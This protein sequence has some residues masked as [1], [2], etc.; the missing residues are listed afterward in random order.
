MKITSYSAP[1]KRGAL[2]ACMVVLLA[3]PFVSASEESQRTLDDMVITASKRESSLDDF[4][5][6]ISVKD[7]QFITDHEIK[8]LSELTLFIP[9]VYFKKTTSG[10]AFVS[11]GISTIDTSLFSPMGLY[12]NDVS[13]PLSFMQNQLLTDVKRVE[14][15]RGPQGTLYG[16][17]SESG[18]INVVLEEPGD[19]LKATAGLS[20]G[21][22]NTWCGEASVSGPVVKDTLYLGLSVTG[23]K[24]DGFIENEVTGKDD[25]AD[26][27]TTAARGTLRW[28]PGERF[29]L[30]ATLDGLD[31]DKGISTLRLEDGPQASDRHKVRSSEEDRAEEE[32][33]GGV[34]KMNWRADNAKFTS[35]TSNRQFTREFTHDFDRTPA[36]LGTTDLDIDQDNWSQEF[37]I[38]SEGEAPLSWL[39]GLFGFTEDLDT[40]M[41]LNHVN[42]A[43]A[44]DRVTDSEND[45]YAIFG[46]ATYRFTDK[47]KLTGGLRGEHATAEGT[48]TFTSIMGPVTFDEKL[49]ETEWLPMA[50]ASYEIA[51]NLT[52]Y[53]TCARG[54]LAGG[55]NYFSANSEETFGYEPEYTVNYETGLKATFF[56]RRLKADFSLFYIDIDD[57]QVREEVPGGGQGIW[58]FSNAGKAHSQGVELDLTALPLGNLEVFAGVG[59]S[60]TEIDT[61][62]G[63]TGGMPFDYSGNSLPWA[64][65]FTWNAG[66]AYYMTNGLYGI[67]DVTGAG[68]QYFDAANT[69]KDDGYALVNLKMGYALGRFDISVYCKNI[70]DEEYATKKVKNMQ[71]F[72]MVE[73]G[74]PLT[75]GLT[76]NWRL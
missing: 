14:V 52:A 13:Y 1:L 17:N 48:Q 4:A 60:D 44:K 61:W 24:T 8:D 16:R 27:E 41:A 36:K 6:S 58:K 18:V 21:N 68:K 25:V 32:E 38:A 66:A 53:A 26:E 40:T 2:A 70:F 62:Q 59:L 69:L 50:S 64:P 31:Q 71:G 29:E 7:G 57:K 49:S 72:T 19:K 30:V 39:V 67:A 34:I 37:R 28:T 15:L 11:R 47:L 65:E 10:D 63:T 75:F 45:G 33:V 76:L 22:Y 9:N 35:I 43:M 5:G 51:D 12:I 3:T 73:D 20:A 56:D 46:Q 23:R 74:E 42:P 54:W 55:F